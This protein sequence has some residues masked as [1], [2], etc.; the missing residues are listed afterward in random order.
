MRTLDVGG[1]KP[2]SYLRTVPEANPFL[3]QRGLRYCLEHP[4]IFKP[5]L[6]AILRTAADYPVSRMFPMVSSW[7]EIGD[8]RCA[9]GRSLR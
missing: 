4:G 1:D 3:G 8:G 9:H 5:Q 2:L 6:R 7:D